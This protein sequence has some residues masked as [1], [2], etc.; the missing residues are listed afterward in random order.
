MPVF[1]ETKNILLTIAKNFNNQLT[2]SLLKI[3]R[4][5]VRTRGSFRTRVEDDA[6]TLENVSGDLCD[7]PPVSPHQ[8]ACLAFISKWTF[9]TR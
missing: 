6:V 7:L 1:I 2:I 3:S 5:G 4:L 9:D 8:R